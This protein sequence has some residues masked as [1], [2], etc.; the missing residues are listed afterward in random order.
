VH[1]TSTARIELSDEGIVVV[2]IAPRARQSLEQA[3]ENLS[4]AIRSADGVKRP[5]YVDISRCEPLS[6]EV[7]HYYSGQALVDAFTALGLRITA[8]PFGRMMGNVY[9][10]VARPG[11]PARL[12][13]DD[14]RAIAWLREFR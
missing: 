5:I 12:F 7:R 11:V 10:R 9:L 13:T 4:C 14:D 1:Q 8:S 6:V 2:R 3:H